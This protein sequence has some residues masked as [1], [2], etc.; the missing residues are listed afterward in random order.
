MKRSSSTPLPTVVVWPENLENKKYV[1]VNTGQGLTKRQSSNNY[2]VI[3]LPTSLARPATFEYPTDDNVYDSTSCSE[4]GGE[5]GEPVTRLPVI[6]CMTDPMPTEETRR[7]QTRHPM[8]DSVNFI[9]NLQDGI[10]HVADIMAQRRIYVLLNLLVATTIFFV[11]DFE[12]IIEV[13]MIIASA[14]TICM[15][16]SFLWVRKNKP[17][18]PRPFKIPGGLFGCIV[19]ALCPLLFIAMYLY[20]SLS[21]PTNRTL[22]LGFFVLMVSFGLFVHLIWKIIHR[23]LQANIKFVGFICYFTWFFFL[24]GVPF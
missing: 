14:N 11:A 9:E 22:R 7:N 5:R 23:I 6:P 2:S 1:N 13:D 4:S 24:G 19:C 20:L 17:E 21:T 8:I 12:M 15:I 10:N 18:E 3:Q 16:L